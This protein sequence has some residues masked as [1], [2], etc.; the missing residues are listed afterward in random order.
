MTIILMLRLLLELLDSTLYL[1]LS[2]PPGLMNWPIHIISNYNMQK[3]KMNDY[4]WKCYEYVALFSIGLKSC[5][6]D[7]KGW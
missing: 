5:L 6:E 4:F 1:V 3:L 2:R 7:P